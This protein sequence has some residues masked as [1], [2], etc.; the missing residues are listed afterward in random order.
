MKT[1]IITALMKTVAGTRP[2]PDRALIENVVAVASEKAAQKNAAAVNEALT[3]FT[4]A[5]A[6]H[7]GSMMA[8]NDI[9]A[10]ITRS[11]KER[12]NALEESAEA[13]KSWRTR[14][15]SLGGAMTPELKAEHG[16]RM[17]GRELAEEFTGLIAE[18]ET[19]K[20]RAMLTACATGRQY[21]D[22]HATALTV[23]AQTAWTEA[24]DTISPLLVRAYRLRLRELEL[25]GEPRPGQVLGEELQQHVALQAQ[26]YTFDM[27]NEPVISQ[28]GL[29]RPPLTGVD[30]TL[31]KSPL[32]RNQLAAE[33]AARKKQAES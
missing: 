13:D 7:T 20:S 29:H 14:L 6:A 24:M 2:A 33:L 19:D 3:R 30:M 11:E 17:A 12:Q 16:R 10:A 21:V 1:E 31:Y 8:L 15:R 27:D 25:K 26:F 32:K 28:L 18:L 5:K 22:E 23:C 9:N 4:E